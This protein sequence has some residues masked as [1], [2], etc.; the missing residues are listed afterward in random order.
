MNIDGRAL[1]ASDRMRMYRD[2]KLQEEVD[3]PMR[4]YLH[5]GQAVPQDLIDHRQALLDVPDNNTPTLD[6]DDELTG[7]TWPTKPE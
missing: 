4:S 3:I 6:K 1:S 7:V 5:S 2:G